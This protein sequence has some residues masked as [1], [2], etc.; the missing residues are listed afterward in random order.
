[1]NIF[2]RYPDFYNENVARLR[3]AESWPCGSNVVCESDSPS[4]AQ[5]TLHLPE[6]L[7]NRCFSVSRFLGF[8][9]SRFLGLDLVS[10]LT[11]TVSNVSQT[12]S[13]D[14]DQLDQLYAYTSPPIVMTL[15]IECGVLNANF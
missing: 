5:N 2:N 8:S 12:L 6:T 1:L 3:S 9:V 11:S 14:N 7:L 13:V 15:L 10:S 4:R